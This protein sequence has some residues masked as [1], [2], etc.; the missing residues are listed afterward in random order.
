YGGNRGNDYNDYNDI[1]LAYGTNIKSI[2]IKKIEIRVGK[3]VDSLQFTYSIVTLDGASHDF[4]GNKYG[5]NG[6]TKQELTLA[7]DEQLTRISGRYGNYEGI[8]TV[9]FL[10]FRTSQNTYRFANPGDR[11]D[12]EDA[13]FTLPVGVIYGSYSLRHHLESIGSVEIAEAIQQTVT[14]TVTSAQ[15]TKSFFSLMTMTI[16][17][18]SP[19]YGGNRGIDYND[20]NDIITAYGGS[21]NIKNINVKRIEIRYGSAVDSLQFT[22]SIVTFDGTSHDYQGNKYGGNRGTKRDLNLTID[23]QLTRISGRHGNF[24]GVTTIKYLEFQTSQNTYCFGGKGNAEDIAFTLPVGVIYGSSGQHLESI[25]S[26][27]ITEAIQPT[28]TTATVTL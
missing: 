11:G 24:E 3:V 7:V 6:G 28:I 19:K 16:K 26:V 23:E 2:N 25:G 22:Y 4:Q 5:G 14:T 15:P 18:I 17:N 21:T 13:A 1:I 10:E 20:F 27:E 8:I 12:T 9:K